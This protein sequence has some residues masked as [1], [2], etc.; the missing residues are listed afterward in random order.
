[1]IHSGCLSLAYLQP[2]YV[3]LLERSFRTMGFCNID[4]QWEKER[5]KMRMQTGIEC[6]EWMRLRSDSGMKWVKHM[7]ICCNSRTGRA[8]WA[9]V[10]MG[11]KISDII[12]LF[13]FRSALGQGLVPSSR[14]RSYTNHPGETW[15]PACTDWS[16]RHSIT[17]TMSLK[18]KAQDVLRRKRSVQEHC[19]SMQE[20]QYISNSDQCDQSSVLADYFG[21]AQD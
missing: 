19:K 21:A 3:F 15:M 6:W 5:K 14:R 9:E 20:Y 1:M 16:C 13:S 10:G 11:E 7:I 4:R 17:P 2:H 12:C 18:A 8:A